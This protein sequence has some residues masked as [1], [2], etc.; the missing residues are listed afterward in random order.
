MAQILTFL[1]KGGCGSTT[2]AI[3]TAKQL[4]AQGRRVLLVIQDVT[5]APGILLGSALTALRQEIQPQ[6]W[7][8]QIHT[9]D[10]LEHS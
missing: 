2:F 6:L 8:L 9:T 4:A 7:A 10:L 3:A 5:P 1:G